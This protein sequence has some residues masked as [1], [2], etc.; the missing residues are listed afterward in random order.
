MTQIQHISH[1]TWDV[2]CHPLGHVKESLVALGSMAL[3]VGITVGVVLGTTGG[4][5]QIRPAA[6]SAATTGPAS[7]TIVEQETLST[8]VAGTASTPSAVYFDPAAGLFDTRSQAVVATGTLPSLIS[9]D[10]AA[11]LSINGTWVDDPA[12]G[13]A[14]YPSR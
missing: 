1:S 11:G 5:E 14:L 9:F 13:M 10:P 2:C 4:S 8:S 7:S 3:A 12:A 6:S